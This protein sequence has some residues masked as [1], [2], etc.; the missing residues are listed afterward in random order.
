LA[1]ADQPEA[2]LAHWLEA[3][4]AA[5]SVRDFARADAMRG[6]LTGAGFVLA[7]RKDGS[8]EVTHAEAQAWAWVW[9]PEGVPLA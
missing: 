7:D 3:R 2:Q 5:R 8:V 9:S 4:R 1:A 6:H